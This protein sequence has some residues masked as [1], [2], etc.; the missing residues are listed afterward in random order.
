MTIRS[1]WYCPNPK[2]KGGKCPFEKVRSQ[3]PPKTQWESF[4][5]VAMFASKND[6]KWQ[7]EGE[8]GGNAKMVNTTKARLWA[9]GCKPNGFQQRADNRCWYS[10]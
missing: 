8:G 9:I 3:P 1:T 5:Q 7:V 4:A 6:N 2:E 10:H